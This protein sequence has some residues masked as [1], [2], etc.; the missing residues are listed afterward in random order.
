MKAN[1]KEYISA[2]KSVSFSKNSTNIVKGVAILILLF[3]HLG[4]SP[5]LSVFDTSSKLFL[6]ALQCKVCVSIFVILSGYGLYFSFENNQ[7]LGF[8]GNI[9][10][11]FRHLK[12]LYFIY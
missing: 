7:I 10:F 3:H 12:K 6:L 9:K 2:N 11:T 1:L 5:D 8:G 4:I